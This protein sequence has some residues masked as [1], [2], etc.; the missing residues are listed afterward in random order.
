MYQKWENKHENWI[1]LNKDHF[2]LLWPL[3]REWL[4]FK[5]QQSFLT[6]DVHPFHGRGLHPLHWAGSRASRG[7]VT[8]SG[9]TNRLNNSVIFMVYPYFTNVADDHIKQRGKPRVWRHMFCRFWAWIRQVIADGEIWFCTCR[10][11]LRCHQLFMI[12]FAHVLTD[13][14]FYLSD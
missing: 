3:M 1:Y 2:Y 5:C 6:L 11:V 8:I 4:L 13:D 12:I 10:I 7:R 14:S 9:I